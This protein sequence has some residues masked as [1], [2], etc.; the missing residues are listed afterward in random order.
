MAICQSSAVASECVVEMMTSVPRYVSPEVHQVGAACVVKAK[1]VRGF[2][3]QIGSTAHLT[4][5][6]FSCARKGHAASAPGGLALGHLASTAT[7]VRID[8]LAQSFRRHQST[9]PRS[10]DCSGAMFIIGHQVMKHQ[11]NLS[12]MDCHHYYPGDIDSFHYLDTLAISHFYYYIKSIRFKF[13]YV[14]PDF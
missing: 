9:S 6:V 14:I 3:S 10:E 1:T 12:S 5:D 4:H 2:R 13:K 8:C 7:G 11:K